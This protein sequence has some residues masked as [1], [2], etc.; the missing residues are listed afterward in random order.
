MN[1]LGFEGIALD[2]LHTVPGTA[3]TDV[4]LEADLTLGA[5]FPRPSSGPQNH[6]QSSRASLQA[7]DQRRGHPESSIAATVIPEQDVGVRHGTA[8]IDEDIGRTEENGG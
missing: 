2:T 5:Q 1:G 8:H 7:H 3:S 4:D 6:V